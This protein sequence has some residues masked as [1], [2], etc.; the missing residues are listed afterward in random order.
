VQFI[1]LRVLYPR[2]WVDCANLGETIRRELG[3]VE[4][5]LRLFQLL[6]GAILSFLHP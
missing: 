5:R 2:L 3:P 4:S 6:A 1:A